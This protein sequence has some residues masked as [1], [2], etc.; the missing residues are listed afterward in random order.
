MNA[1]HVRWCRTWAVL[2]VLFALILAAC[3][4]NAT[5][6]SASSPTQAART[7][8]QPS[9]AAKPTA[10]PTAKPRATAKPTAAA[11]R[12]G[13]SGLPTVR[14]R[15]LPPE[16]RETLALIE[17]GGPFPY[18]RD[19]ITFQNRERILPREPAGYYRE[20][21]VPT[22]GE[23]DR[24]ARRLVVGKQ[25]EIYYTSDHYESFAEVVP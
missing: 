15:E 18:D 24:G 7:R 9:A 12:V 19:G 25:G 17:E 23:D 14:V 8:A 3:G 1:A 22:P 4:T 16:A 13:V 11:S 10:K 5:E 6:Q 20:Y 21:T 2:G